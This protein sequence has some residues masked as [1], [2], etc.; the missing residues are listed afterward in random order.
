MSTSN[1]EDMGFDDVCQ[2]PQ[3]PLAFHNKRGD[4]L[5]FVFQAGEFRRERIDDLVTVYCDRDSDEIVGGTVKGISSLMAEHPGICFLFE[6]EA[7]KIQLSR[8]LVYIVRDSKLLDATPENV[9]LRH[10]KRLL[11]CAESSKADVEL[12]PSV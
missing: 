8:L 12:C 2:E 10:Y 1:I 4:C 3:Y 5:D 9:P 7:G 11:E 6:N